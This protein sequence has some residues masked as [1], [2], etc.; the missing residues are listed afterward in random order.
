MPISCHFRHCKALLVASL[1]S[2]NKKRYSKYPTFDLY[3]S[4]VRWKRIAVRRRCIRCLYLNACYLYTSTASNCSLFSR[5]ANFRCAGTQC[6]RRSPCGLIAHTATWSLWLRTGVADGD[7]KQYHFSVKDP[8]VQT[9]R[10]TCNAG[11]TP[12]TGDKR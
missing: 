8:S 6:D 4:C 10:R 5:N 12:V 2:C 9:P 1:D 11:P 7:N 3:A